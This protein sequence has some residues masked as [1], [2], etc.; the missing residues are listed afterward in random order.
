MFEDSLRK[1]SKIGLNYHEDSVVGVPG[2]EPGTSWSQ[3][4]RASQLRYTPL[5]RRTTAPG[6][7]RFRVGSA[8]FEP[9]TSTMSR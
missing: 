2:L 3:T 7:A 5:H 6:D 8:G 9:A 4:M 1:C